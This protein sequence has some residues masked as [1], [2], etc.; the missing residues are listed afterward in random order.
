MP[1]DLWGLLRFLAQGLKPIKSR[2]HF[3]TTKELAENAKDSKEK[4]QGPKLNDLFIGIYGTTEV[5]PCYKTGAQF[6][7]SASCKVVP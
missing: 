5:V 7:F 3:G 1:T 4:A 6:G 2:G